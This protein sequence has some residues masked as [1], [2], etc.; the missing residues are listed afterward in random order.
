MRTSLRSSSWSMQWICSGRA[1]LK[2][3]ECMLFSAGSE[4]TATTL[5]WAVCFM[6]LHP[7][8]QTRVQVPLSSSPRLCNVQRQE[9][10]DAVLGDRGLGLADRAL[11]PLTQVLC[12]VHC[13]TETLFCAGDYNGGAAAGQHRPPGRAAQNPPPRHRAGPQ[14]AGRLPRLLHAAP[15]HAGPGLLAATGTVLASTLPWFFFR[16]FTA[17][18][19]P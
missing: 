16:T 9:E 8:C 3:V 1:A 7:D 13:F 10:I 5:G 11:L 18:K 2:Y 4:T 17:I 6:I 14:P 15:H 12:S 19:L